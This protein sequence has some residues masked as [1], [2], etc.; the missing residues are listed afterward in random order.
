M[1]HAARGQGAFLNWRRLK[2]TSTDSLEQAMLATGFPPDVRGQERTLD[3]WRWFSFHARALRRTGST[4]LNLAY[5]AAGRFDGYYAFD[6]HVWD[7]AGG[8]VV[9]REAGGVI[10][11]VDGS[12]YDAHTPDALASNGPLHPALLEAMRQ[13]PRAE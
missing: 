6:N 8:V 2:T 13:D 1:Y 10:T 7:V 5:L 11:N 4:A 9:L 12:H 3:W